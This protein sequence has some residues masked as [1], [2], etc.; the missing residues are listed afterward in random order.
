MERTLTISLV[1]WTLGCCGVAMICRE[2][3]VDCRGGCRGGCHGIT[4]ACHGISHGAME[5][6][7]TLWDAVEMP[8]YAMDGAMALPRKSLPV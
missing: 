2:V 5:S 7:A 3:V 1:P 4:L 8:W 6:Y